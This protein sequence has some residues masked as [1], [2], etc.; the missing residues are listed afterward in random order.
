MKKSSAV[1]FG[2]LMFAVGVIAGYALSP[3]K[4]GKFGCD[5]G[6]TTNNFYGK[7]GFDTDGDETNELEEL[8]GVE[9]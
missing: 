1:L 2:L 8:D 3:A 4:N 9:D 7:D 5:N 6:N